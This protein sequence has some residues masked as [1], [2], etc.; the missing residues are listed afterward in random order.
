MPRLHKI[1]KPYPYSILPVRRP[2]PEIANQLNPSNVQEFFRIELLLRSER[3]M[4]IYRNL[5]D[6]FEGTIELIN[7]YGLGWHALRGKHH[8]LLLPKTRR[9]VPVYIQTYED[10][11]KS[12]KSFLS[13]MRALCEPE[14]ETIDRESLDGVR[15]NFLCLIQASPDIPVDDI[16]AQLRPIL[17]QRQ[18]PSRQPYKFN[19]TTWLDYLRCYD[20]HI[21]EGRSCGEIGKIVYGKQGSSR[22]FSPKTACQRVLTFIR[23]AEQG[24]W[25]PSKL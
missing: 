18:K 11:A 19:L 8:R 24:N 13:T 15:R 20:L 9:H 5:G 22:R 16:L 4:E 3:V 7:R 12:P 25:P 14:V 6:T 10:I 17:V 2:S 23:A 1:A 21:S